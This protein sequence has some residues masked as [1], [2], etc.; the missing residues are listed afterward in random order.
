[1]HGEETVSTAQEFYLLFHFWTDWYFKDASAHCCR[2][3]CQKLFLINNL[4]SLKT[5]FPAYVGVSIQFPST[6]IV[7]FASP[8]SEWKYGTLYPHLKLM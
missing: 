1:M 6:C 2:T 3:P 4:L 5:R 8:N 7:D